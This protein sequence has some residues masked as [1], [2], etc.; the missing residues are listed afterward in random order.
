VAFPADL[1]VVIG[2]QRPAGGPST[3]LLRSVVR[4]LLDVLVAASTADVRL[5]RPR[6][7]LARLGV[8]LPV[9]V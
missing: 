8:S 5:F 6:I 3:G 7:L 9:L 2:A 1:L 4:S